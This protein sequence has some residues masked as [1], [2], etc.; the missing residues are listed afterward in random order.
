MKGLTFWRFDVL[1]FGI[2]LKRKAKKVIS[3]FTSLFHGKFVFTNMIFIKT[4]SK[5]NVINCEI[6]KNNLFRFYIVNV[7]NILWHFTNVWLYLQMFDCIYKCLIVTSESGNFA[8][9]I[10]VIWTYKS[11]VVRTNDFQKNNAHWQFQ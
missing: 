5:N 6:N 4:I 9:L 7:L 10:Y 3:N 2:F 8:D 11:E 1:T